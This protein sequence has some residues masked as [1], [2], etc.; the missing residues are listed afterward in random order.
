MNILSES[1]HQS[2]I[3]NYCIQRSADSLC[4]M[5]GTPPP[6]LMRACI[7]EAEVRTNERVIEE[8]TYLDCVARGHVIASFSGIEKTSFVPQL[9]PIFVHQ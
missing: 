4:D 3:M 9:P 2:Q 6:A 5:Y 8:L 7:L 1:A